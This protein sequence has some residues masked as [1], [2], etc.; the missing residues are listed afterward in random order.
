M[1]N[2]IGLAADVVERR[3]AIETVH[4]RVFGALGG[5]RGGDLLELHGEGPVLL[6]EQRRVH[7]IEGG[8]ADERRAALGRSIA[9]AR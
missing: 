3:Q 9:C 2:T 7:E 8:G 4:R 5:H 1:P 6:I